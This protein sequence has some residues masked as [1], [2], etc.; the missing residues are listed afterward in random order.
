MLMTLYN[1]AF[2]K[3]KHKTVYHDRKPWLT[4]AVKKSINVKNR[5]YVIKCKHNTV[6]NKQQYKTYRNKVVKLLTIADKKYHND[7][8]I[9]NKSD[10]RKN[11]LIIEEIL[12]KSKSKELRHVNLL[13]QMV[14]RLTINKQLQ[15]KNMNALSTSV[16]R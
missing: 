8:L 5:L 13:H 4:Q 15:K 12:N 16:S 11:W 9:K 10:I 14:N 3:V 6:Y 2:P 1:E 7:I